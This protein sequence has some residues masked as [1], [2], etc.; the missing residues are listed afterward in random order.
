MA[1]KRSVSK[2]GTRKPARRKRIVVHMVGAPSSA[3]STSGAPYPSYSGLLLSKILSSS[4]E[5]KSS[6]LSEFLCALY[7]LSPTMSRMSYR[8]GISKGRLLYRLDL[9]ARVRHKAIYRNEHMGD[10]LDFLEA[11]G[12]GRTTF[13]PT[14]HGTIIRVYR[15]SPV[16]FGS[17]IHYFEAGLI[18]GFLGAAGESIPHVE[19]SQCTARGD[20]L[21]EYISMPL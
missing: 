19:E 20:G 2:K 8:F 3:N 12:I 7:S 10:V 6:I 18:A 1:R 13:H 11:A 21:C 5:K 4:D 15:D 16:I 9:P 17:R 14:T